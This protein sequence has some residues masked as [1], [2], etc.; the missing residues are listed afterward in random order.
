[1][2]TDQEAEALC[3]GQQVNIL[4]DHPDGWEIM[5]IAELIT[6]ARAPAE[7]EIER[8]K[9]QL[10]EALCTRN[11]MLAQ[12]ISHAL[13]R[14]EAAEKDAQRWRLVRCGGIN[15]LWITKIDNPPDCRQIA[16]ELADATVDAALSAKESP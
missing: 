4:F 11:V 9:E 15:A 5:Q 16:F 13:A 7:Q 8:L 10:K 12:P 14:A 3:L 6:L 2:T 1:M